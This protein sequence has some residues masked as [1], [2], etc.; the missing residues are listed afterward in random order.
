M[1]KN[2]LNSVLVKLLKIAVGE[3]VLVRLNEK[4]VKELEKA[5]DLRVDN[6]IG[7]HR[8]GY[9]LGVYAVLKKIRDGYLV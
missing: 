1:F 7:P 6:D 2:Y 3:K 5:F 8:A 9:L 4:E